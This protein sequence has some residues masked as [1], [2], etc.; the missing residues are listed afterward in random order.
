[1]KN[2]Q[3]QETGRLYSPARLVSRQMRA[4]KINEP[5]ADF[6][7]DII[8]EEISRRIWATNRDFSNA[9]DFYSFSGK[10]SQRLNKLNNVSVINRFEM[11]AVSHIL[12]KTDDIAIHPLSMTLTKNSN[13]TWPRGLDLVVSALGLHSNNRLPQFL[14]QTLNSMKKDGLLLIALP[15]RG[16]LAELQDCLTR[17]ELELAGG[18]AMRTDPFI[19]LQEAGSLLQ[20]TGFKLPVV[21]REEIVARYDN[22]FALIRDLRGM[23]MTST[24][25]RGNYRP[26]HRHLFKRAD[27]LYHKDYSDADGRIR[28]SFCFAYLT[29]WSPHENQQ[30]P[31]KPGSAK[32][33]LEQYLDKN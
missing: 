26:A 9:A 17:A 23:G 20:A 32:T 30:K 14:L 22:I 25:D 7:V 19:N 24:L 6:L 18:A 15:V 5:K 28:A 16:T 3:S 4:I 2:P 8:A 27:E 31:L 13:D 10:L 33:R 11:P 12:P 21:D 1:M 29:G